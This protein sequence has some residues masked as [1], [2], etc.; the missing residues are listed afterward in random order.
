MASFSSLLGLFKELQIL[1]VFKGSRKLTFLTF[2]FVVFIYSLKIIY[3][4][5]IGAIRRKNIGLFTIIYNTN[6][7]TIW[8]Y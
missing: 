3:F 1:V 2:V 5:V 6:S 8:C 4:I 7:E